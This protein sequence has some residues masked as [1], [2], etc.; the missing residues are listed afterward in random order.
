VVCVLSFQAKTSGDSIIVIT[1]PGAVTSAQQQL[2]VT[3]AQISIQ[4]K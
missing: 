3:G 4:V 2:P 1:H